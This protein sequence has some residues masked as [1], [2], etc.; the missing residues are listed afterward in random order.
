MPRG[1][2]PAFARL[3]GEGGL[4]SPQKRFRRRGVHLILFPDKAE[5]VLPPGCEGAEG[6]TA[7]YLRLS[8]EAEAQGQ[9]CEKY[10]FFLLHDAN[11]LKNA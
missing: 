5:A 3:R 4:D 6:E 11:L 10:V 9:C 2:E 8:D 7:V 1:L